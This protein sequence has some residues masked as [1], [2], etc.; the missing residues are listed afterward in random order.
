MMPLEQQHLA[1]QKPVPACPLDSACSQSLLQVPRVSFLSHCL[2]Q[3]ADTASLAAA[4]QLQ[5]DLWL[6][7]CLQL[8]RA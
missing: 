1:L 7:Q 5:S 8:E 4:A 6:Q 2:A 3:P